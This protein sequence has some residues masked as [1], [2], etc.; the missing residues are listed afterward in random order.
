MRLKRT[1]SSMTAGLTLVELVT[2]MAC[3]I[4]V[5]AALAMLLSTGTMLFAKNVATNASHVA[6]RTALDRIGLAVTSAAGQPS[7]VG[8]TGNAVS[9]GSAAGIRFDQSLGGPYVVAHPGGA[10]ISAAA[11]TVTVTRSL[12]SLA[13]PPLP[14]AG[15]VLLVDGVPNVRLRVSSVAP[16]VVDA[17]DRQQLVVTL[18]APP[19]VAISWANTTTKIARL[20]RA[21]AFVVV[22][23]NGRNQLRHFSNAE[24]I[25]NFGLASN[26]S[27]ICDNIGIGSADKTPFSLSISTDSSNRKYVDLGLRIR[28]REYDVRLA[29]Q[30]KNSF[31]SVMGLNVTLSPKGQ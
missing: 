19:G 4:L 11:S 31:S 22:P 5:M 21:V 9:S 27:V 28:A 24:T 13:S 26:Y 25:T 30:E 23:V 6:M 17:A 10:G 8:V 7:L 29:S 16:G 1:I 14:A 20:V 12:H 3:G 2:T 15:D 18:D